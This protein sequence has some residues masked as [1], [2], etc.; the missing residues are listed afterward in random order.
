M[1]GGAYFG[2]DGRLESPVDH[3]DEGIES[4]V[5]E[6][7]DKCIQG[8]RSVAADRDAHYGAKERPLQWRV[9]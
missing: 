2:R 6:P 8:E 9:G 7:R 4:L 3:E 5:V 1:D